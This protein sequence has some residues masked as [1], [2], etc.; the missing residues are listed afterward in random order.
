MEIDYKIRNIQNNILLNLSDDMIKSKNYE[1]VLERLTS[2]IYNKYVKEAHKELC[3]ELKKKHYDM[4]DNLLYF[5][6]MPKE[7]IM[8]LKQLKQTIRRGSK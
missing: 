5:D 6:G 2:L 1:D 4:L 3:K 7:Y 8:K